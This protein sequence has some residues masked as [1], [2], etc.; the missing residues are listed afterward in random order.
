[1]A[2]MKILYDLQ[3]NKSIKLYVVSPSKIK[4]D[5]E[6]TSDKT[7]STFKMECTFAF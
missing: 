7:N 3:D 5:N 4:L 6:I 2:D 1:M